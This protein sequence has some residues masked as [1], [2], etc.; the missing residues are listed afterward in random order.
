M[1]NAQEV[2][3]NIQQNLSQKSSSKKDEVLVM[4]AIMNDPEYTVDV[5]K[6]DG[7]QKEYRPGKELRKVISN[8]IAAIT[9][10]PPKEAAALVQNY[11]FSKSDAATI[12][13]VSK[14]FINSYLQTGRK[15]SLG[16]RENSDVE[17]LWKDIPE[18]TISVPVKDGDQR[19]TAIVPKHGGIKAIS[20]CPKWIKK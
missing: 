19:T 2:I 7:N 8:A 3:N 20:P 12:V 13:G 9:N 16:G 18:K 14:E 10:M 6:N 15:L 17:L 11:E 4:K 5:Y 1:E